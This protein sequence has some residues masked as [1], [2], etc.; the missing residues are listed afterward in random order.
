MMNRAKLLLAAA[1]VGGRADIKVGKP[2]PLQIC[3][4]CGGMHRTGKEFCSA[5]CCREYRAKKRKLRR[6][7]TC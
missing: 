1:L 3:P 7:E 5:D 2:K 4:N 6:A